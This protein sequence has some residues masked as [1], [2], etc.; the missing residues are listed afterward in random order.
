MLWILPHLKARIFHGGKTVKTST[1]YIITSTTQQVGEYREKQ[2]I[3]LRQ[4]QGRNTHLERKDVDILSN[5]EEHFFFHT[6]LTGPRILPKTLVLLFAKMDPTT[7][8]CGNMSTLTMGWCPLPFDLQG[9]FLHMCR[10]EVFL[11]L[12]SR[13]LISLLQQSSASSTS[14][15]FGVSG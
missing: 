6:N 14:F 9:A 1:K 12:K 8:A 3:Y 15:V 2:F 10:R 4:R 7:E 11:D 13:H 5:E